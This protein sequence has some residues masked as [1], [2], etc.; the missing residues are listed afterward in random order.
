MTTISKLSSSLARALLG[1]SCVLGLAVAVAE[2]AAAADLYLQGATAPGGAIWVEDGIAPANGHLWVA[3]HIQGFCRLNPSSAANTSA[4][5]QTSTCKPTGDGQ[6]AY[7]PA[8]QLAFS[9]DGSA[10]SVGVMRLRLKAGQFN[11]GQTNFNDTLPVADSKCKGNTL[12][13]CRP[14]AVAFIQ[15]N[16]NGNGDLY[17]AVK[18]NGN[19]YRKRNVANGSGNI[20]GTNPPLAYTGSPSAL[21]LVGTADGA[22]SMTF[23]GADLYIAEAGS[24]LVTR[25]IDPSNVVTGDG[26]GLCNS[27]S[28]RGVCAADDAGF[29]FL[30]ALSVATDGTRLIV[31]DATNP[32]QAVNVVDID[33]G[34]VTPFQDGGVYVNVSGMAFA[35]ELTSGTGGRPARFFWADDPTG[36]AGVLQGHW[37]TTEAANLP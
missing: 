13:G 2:G 5:L 19:I 14:S 33:S 29:S 7:S 22:L 15:T 31:G 21:Q 6:P 28:G 25:I 34:I 18:R 26:L 24:G 9:P 20:P 27:G 30:G 37:F 11:G 16:A 17:I 32:L 23:V 8:A 36:G 35:P 4:T 12:G 1:T 3:D 10:K